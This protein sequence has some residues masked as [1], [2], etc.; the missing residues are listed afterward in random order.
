MHILLAIGVTI[1]AAT[2]PQAQPS[3]LTTKPVSLTFI[4]SVTV[5]DAMTTIG[6]LAQV[7]VEFDQTV[8][9]DVRGSALGQTINM[10]DVT[11]EQVVGF[12]AD[13][14]GLSY[15]VDGKT[16]VIFKKP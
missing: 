4:Q 6:R 11:L 2:Q 8:S 16:I 12:L 14:K 5:E 3:A 10:R 13:L 7:T 15:R 9:A 1:L